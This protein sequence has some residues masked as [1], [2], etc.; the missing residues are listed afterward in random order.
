MLKAADF[1]YLSCTPE[2]IAD[3]IAYACR[4]LHFTF[5]RMHSKP[6]RRLQRIIAGIA[7]ELALR[8]Y[9][10]Q[11]EIPYNILGGTPFTQPD[12]Y[13]IAI[14]GRRCDIKSFLLTHKKRIRAIRR[15]PEQ[16]LRAHALVPR[17]QFEHSRLRP[18]DVYIFAFLAALTAE[19]P[20]QM[21]KAL[22]RGQPVHLIHLLPAA[23]VHQEGSATLG[24]LALKN[25]GERPLTVELGGLAGE[26]EFQQV[27]VPLPPG[28]RVT[29]EADFAALYYIHP[30]S[31]LDGPL[32]IHSPELKEIHIVEPQQWRNIWVYGMEI[33]FTGLIS[34]REFEG[35]ARRIPAGSRVY[36][37]PR[38]STANLGLPVR[39]LHPLRPF[40]RQARAWR[41]EV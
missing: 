29:T 3:G 33:Y 5:N 19:S 12:R 10:E 13:D 39:E 14:G 25:G 15:Q 36:Q 23:W 31:L 2:L 35:R 4:S 21:K 6:V 7:V 20:S 24:T 1:I 34:R 30:D 17:D 26:G 22:A 38:T 27:K 8:R 41:A 11:E 37:Y 40:F 9:L 16:L 32:G 28:K 18:E